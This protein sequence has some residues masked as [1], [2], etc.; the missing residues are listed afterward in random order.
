MAKIVEFRAEDTRILKVV[1]IRPDGNVVI[2]GG[3]NESG[4]TTVLDDIELIFSGAKSKKMPKVPIRGGQASG[5]TSVT[6]D[7][8]MVLEREWN[9]SGTRLII[10]DA[11]GKKITGGTQA[12]ADKFFSLVA[13][14]PLEFA[15]KMDDKKQA[16]VLRQLVGMD[17]SA[18]DAEHARL[19][20]ERED[21]GRN[22]AKR[23]GQL[24]MM[25]EIK[26]A[27]DVEISVAALMA[28]KEAA[29]AVNAG[30]E[31]AR[32]G[33]SDM[34]RNISEQRTLV[35]QLDGQL[36]AARER[37]AKL[38]EL[39]ALNRAKV[40]SLVYVDTSQ[41]VAKIKGADTINQ[42]VREQRERAKTETEVSAMEKSRLELT[43]RME[44]IDAKKSS[45]LGSVKW[46]VDGLGFNADGVTYKGF[47]FSQASKAAR[48]RVSIAIGSSL[49]PELPCMLIRDA[50]TLDDKSMALIAS[51]AEE[52]GQMLW[53][54]RVGK[55]D[56]GA[57]ILEDGEVIGKVSEPGKVVP[58]KN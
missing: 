22:L 20:S 26:N 56:V 33:W 10:R 28:E 40:E 52:K 51:L 25:P 16:E 19:Y 7:N 57:I 23:K 54:E 15:D 43:A 39:S 4:K 36:Q 8:G 12:I 18:M 45:M 42:S 11:D 41:I 27:P 37:L 5:R 30:N 44:A 58:I 29:D 32:L 47:P 13:F 6:L 49:N 53:I 31:R 21:Q 17:F 2:I 24:A 55:N 14:D 46:P 38:E 50:S 3:D 48:Y 35:G 34:K 9:A 1:R